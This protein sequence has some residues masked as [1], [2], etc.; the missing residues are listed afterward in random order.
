M[1]MTVE[2]GVS[3]ANDSLVFSWPS[4][5]K[6]RKFPKLEQEKFPLPKGD[7]RLLIISS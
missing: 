3:T 4:I 2:K 5:E 1:V 7:G 6:Y